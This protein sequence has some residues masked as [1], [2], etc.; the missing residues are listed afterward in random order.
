MLTNLDSDAI[1][2]LYYSMD[3]YYFKNAS[4]LINI[5]TLK[6]TRLLKP[7]QVNIFDN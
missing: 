7:Q 4:F 2:M 5:S 6:D 1:M 3:K